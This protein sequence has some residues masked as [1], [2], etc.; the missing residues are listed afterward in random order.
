MNKAFLS[1][2]PIKKEIFCSNK[3]RKKM[4]CQNKESPCDID[5][6]SSCM[7]DKI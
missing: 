2:F 6:F 5:I 3:E 7:A 4:C 1:D